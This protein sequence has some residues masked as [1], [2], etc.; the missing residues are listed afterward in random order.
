MSVPH[1]I[2][3]IYERVPWEPKETITAF[4]GVPGPGLVGTI[5]CLHMI[6]TLNLTQIASLHTSLLP[7]VSIFHAGVLQHPLRIYG[8]S[9][10]KL[11]V[12]TTEI[13]LPVEA[14]FHVSRKLVEWLISKKTKILVTLEGAELRGKDLN[15]IFGIAE[16]E[17]LEKLKDHGVIPLIKGYIGGMTGALMNECIVRKE[18]DAFG[19]LTPLMAKSKIPDPGAAARLIE[20]IN[21]IFQLNISTKKLL[22]DATLIETKLKELAEKAK[23]AKERESKKVAG[24]YFV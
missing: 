9:E 11:L 12:V 6:S 20:K 4:V 7:P 24:T 13:P 2:I 15:L 18:I 10:G 16:E 17:I 19:L 14:M 22:A 8:D 1:E 23:M 5:A 21:D 3:E